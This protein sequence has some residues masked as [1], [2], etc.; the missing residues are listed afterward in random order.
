MILKLVGVIPRETYALEDFKEM[1]MHTYNKLSR[2]NAGRQY[3]SFYRSAH[4]V[5]LEHM[6]TATFVGQVIENGNPTAL[7]QN[8]IH[9]YSVNRYATGLST[10]G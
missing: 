3:G 4:I 6:Y 5:I 9:F 2:V 7:Q 8:Y 10:L 1:K